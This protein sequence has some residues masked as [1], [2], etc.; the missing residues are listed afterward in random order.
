MRRVLKPGGLGLVLEF[1]KPRV[2]PIKQVFGLYFKH[3]MPTVGR[4]VSKDPRPTPTSQ[5]ASMRS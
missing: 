1:S 3:I 5:K 2:F 4:W